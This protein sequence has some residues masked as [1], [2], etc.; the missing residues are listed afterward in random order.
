MF[1]T[2]MSLHLLKSE[3]ESKQAF[4]GVFAENLSRQLQPVPTM[5]ISC[6]VLMQC[7]SKGNI[8]KGGGGGEGRESLGEYRGML[9]QKILKSRGLEMLLPAFSKSYL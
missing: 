2:S 8:S 1:I 9:P 5:V 3:L 7:R 4:F 6:T